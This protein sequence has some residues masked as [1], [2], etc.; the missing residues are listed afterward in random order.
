[1]NLPKFFKEKS[2][3]YTSWEIEHNGTFHFIDSEVVIE[4]ILSTRGAER[5]TIANTLFALDFKNAS[6]I[7]YLHFLAK[8]MIANN[9]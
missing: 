7:E 1:M 6:I 2:I 4:A 5:N 3:P 9:S 8:A